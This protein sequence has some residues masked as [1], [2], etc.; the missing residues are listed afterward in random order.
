MQGF[1]RTEGM[2]SQGTF[3]D[4]RMPRPGVGKERRQTS[5]V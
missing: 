1:F 3:Q 4:V 5:V 2:V